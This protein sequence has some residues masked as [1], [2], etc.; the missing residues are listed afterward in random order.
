MRFEMFDDHGHPFA[1]SG[2]PLDVSTIGLF[3]DEGAE[4]DQRRRES[5][6]KRLSSHLM[7][8]RLATYLD[9]DESQLSEARAQASVEWPTY[10]QALLADAGIDELIFDVGA[11]RTSDVADVYAELVERPV[12]WIGRIDP[13]IDEL[14]ASGN[15][16][17]AIVDE[18]ARY[19][20]ES[21][22]AGC[23]GFKTAMAYRTG[24]AV[25]AN[26]TI[27]QAQAS[28]DAAVPV[29]RR[30]KACRDLAFQRA[31]GVAAE[32]QHPFQIHT[33]FGDSSLRLSE[34]N[35]L[36]LEDILR[37]DEGSSTPIVLIHGSYP[38]TEELGFLAMSRANVFAEVSLF[39]LFTPLQ[40]TE[41][42]IQ[43]LGLVPTDRIMFGTDGHEEPESFWFAAHVLHD[44]WAQAADALMSAG[45]SS[46][47]IDEAH[48][49][50][51]DRTA[52][53]LYL[54]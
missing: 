49:D 26:V 22:A 31:L 37:S 25:Q 8:R 7:A 11:E 41:R 35:P 17:E 20:R 14:M 16:A 6:T 24:L 13:L 9:C 23:V 40:V 27:D 2:G 30:G 43:L 10:V 32:T 36:L 21:V 38:W 34:S 29:R 5:S 50:V 54:G 33:G 42:L 12:H 48:L 51:F 52:R 4:A 3:I 19:C 15:D 39:N 28:L 47:W 45:A 1:R 46:T 53:G 44:S 18:V